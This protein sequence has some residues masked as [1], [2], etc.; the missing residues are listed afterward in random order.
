M[1][2]NPAHDEIYTIKHYVIKFVSYLWQVSGFLRVLRFS[3]PIKL[4]TTI[5]LKVALNTRTITLNPIFLIDYFAFQSFDYD[6]G[7]FWNNLHQVRFW[8]NLHQVRF[9]NN[10]HQVR[11]KSKDWKPNNLKFWEQKTLFINS[12]YA[13][14]Y[15]ISHLYFN[16]RF[17][18]KLPTEDVSM[19]V[20]FKDIL[21]TN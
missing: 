6:E 19:L 1:G 15:I 3:P 8:N 9:W 12:S 20:F 7:Y 18:D 17:S 14:P 2:S 16:C 10:L 4:T 13:L 5:L 21:K 11:S